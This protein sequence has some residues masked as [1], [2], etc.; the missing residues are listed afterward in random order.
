[1]RSSSAAGS[2]QRKIGRPKVHSEMKTSQASASNGS[3]SPS[4]PVL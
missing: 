2:G 1:M 3:D 4:D